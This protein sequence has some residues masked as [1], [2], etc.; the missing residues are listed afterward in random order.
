VFEFDV[1]GL[2]VHHE[3]TF[4]AV[5]PFVKVNNTWQPVEVTWVKSDGIWRPVSGSYAP[6]FTKITGNFGTPGRVCISVIDECSRSASTMQNSWN[7]F[8]SLH[9]GTPFYLLQPGGPGEGN[10]EVP[11]N[12]ASNSG[13]GPIT[14][15]RDNGSTSLISDWFTLCGL[16]AYPAGSVVEIS[17]DNSGSMTTSTVSA[18]YDYFVS[19]CNAAGLTVRPISMSS[20]NWVAPFI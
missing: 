2:Y 6:E 7:S 4:R 1:N 3:G 15:D 10:L 18:S 9:S 16:S 11:S 19:Q 5:A 20:E 13:V 12:F 17:I 8:L 14:V